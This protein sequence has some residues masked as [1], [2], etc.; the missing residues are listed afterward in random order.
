MIYFETEEAV[1]IHDDQILKYGGSY[2]I[3]D[4]GLLLSALEMPKAEM[5]GHCLHPTVFDKASAYIFHILC[6]HPFIDGNKRTATACGLI[7]LSMN[8]IE[9]NVDWKD[10]EKMVL[11]IANGKLTKK[12]ISEFLEKYSCKVEK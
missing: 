2:G 12:E 6:N 4:F 9:L 11:D 5:F 8:G 7:F 1:D 10:I 3:R